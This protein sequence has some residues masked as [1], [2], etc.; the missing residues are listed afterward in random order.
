MTVAAAVP[1]PLSQTIAPLDRMM[2]IVAAMLATLMQVLDTTI[3]TVA[4]PHMQT[5]L[6]AT[7]ETVNWVLTSYIVA[8][9]VA[10]PITGWLADRIGR[11][12]LFFWTIVGF[13]VA[14]ALCAIATSLAEMVAFRIVQGIAGAF[15]LPLSQSVMF[16]INPPEK[17]ARGMAMFTA[18]VVIGPILGPVLGGWLTDNFNWRWV[19]I[20]NLPICVLS[21]LLMLRFLPK[22]PR[23]ERRFDLAGFLLLA[24]ALAAFQMM[25]DRGQDRDWFESWEV[26]I[27]AGLAIS[28][29]WMFAVHMA[30]GK[31]P[32]FDPKMFADRNFATALIF[33]VTSGILL[34]GGLA[35][36]APMLQSLLGYSVLQSGLLTAPRGIGTLISIIF[37]GRFIT[38]F[39]PRIVMAVGTL[40]LALSLYQMSGFS[41]DMDRRLIIESGLIQGLGMGLMFVPLNLI[42]F[43]TLPAHYRTSAASVLTLLRSLGGSIGISAMTVLLA[44]NIQ[45]SHSDLASQIT[46]ASMPPVEPSIL[47]M[48]GSGGD[49][50]M[51]MLDAEINRQAAMIAYVDDFH[52][53]MIMTLAS[54]PLLALLRRP[55]V[56]GKP[57]MVLE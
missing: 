15:I 7:R 26:W 44:R 14:S 8:S 34:M 10:I 27:E 24:L 56:Q 30:T 22:T 48:L 47:S 39:D 21:T 25:L 36:L 52:V 33:M 40:L 50:V 18:G 55:K 9:A 28:A 42:A 13:T 35:L 57:E 37:V 51:M 6:G 11:K 41:L 17:H 20:I 38:K 4:L 43:G 45:T 46:P 32:I 2:I 54:L 49:S 19:F 16:D 3:A 12:R 1:V 53:M 5:S 29:A 31:N 23:S